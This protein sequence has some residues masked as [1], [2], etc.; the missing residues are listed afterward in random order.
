MTLSS[1]E[2]VVIYIKSDKSNSANKDD[3]IA[4][5]LLCYLFAIMLFSIWSDLFQKFMRMDLTVYFVL[6]LQ[7]P[8][9]EFLLRVSYL[10]IYN[11]VSIP[12]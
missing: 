8:G 2:A 9:R 1:Q 6:Y 11:E 3:Q 12:K 5:L 4:T 7:T 10:E